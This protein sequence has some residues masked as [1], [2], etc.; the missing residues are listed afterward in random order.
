MIS[1]E[2]FVDIVIPVYNEGENILSVLHALDN[3]V[4]SPIRILICYDSDEDT[5]L[6]AVNNFKG[7]YDIVLIKNEGR[8]AHGAVMT[9][10][11]YSS[12][13]AVISYMADDDYNAG[14]IDD[15]HRQSRYHA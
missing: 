11:R 6:P 3:K 4:H 15:W 14:L 1:P 9:A 7:K 2:F 5:T 12:A 13:P 10:F 8:F